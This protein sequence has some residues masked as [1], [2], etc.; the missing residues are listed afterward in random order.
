MVLCVIVSCC[1][2]L[3]STLLNLSKCVI[4]NKFDLK[5][6]Q[7]RKLLMTVNVLIMCM[8]L[9]SALLKT[10]S[11]NVNCSSVISTLQFYRLYFFHQVA[12]QFGSVS[13]NRSS[14]EQRS[15]QVVTFDVWQSAAGGG[16]FLTSAK[17]LNRVFTGETQ[18]FGWFFFIK[19][20]R[21]LSQV[22]KWKNICV[23]PKFYLNWRTNKLS[24]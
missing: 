12:K 16:D 15:H 24:W 23:Q 11:T 2:L 13:S 17:V 14:R 10:P 7:Q 18:T 3:L 4:L 19:L 8:V 22:K 21:T 6:N 5:F 20:P 9:L 1:V